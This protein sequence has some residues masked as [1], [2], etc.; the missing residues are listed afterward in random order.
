MHLA[1]HS[2][3]LG[4]F[5]SKWIKTN[6][7]FPQITYSGESAKLELWEFKALLEE[8]KDNILGQLGH[9]LKHDEKIFQNLVESI[10]F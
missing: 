4:K 5:L 6:N 2:F 8:G 1:F 9:R 10:W 3:S 7:R